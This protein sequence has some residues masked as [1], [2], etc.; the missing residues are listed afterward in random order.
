MSTVYAIPDPVVSQPGVPVWE[1]AC[2]FSAQRE[3]NGE[4]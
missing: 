2:L 3:W 1:I 4:A